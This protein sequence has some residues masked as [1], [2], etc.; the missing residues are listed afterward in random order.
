MLRGTPRYDNFS[1][2]RASGRRL[3]SRQGRHSAKG[4]GGCCD[5]HQYAGTGQ[6]GETHYF[7]LQ[8][9][10]LAYPCPHALTTC[11]PELSRSTVAVARNGFAVRE[12]TPYKYIAVQGGA[13]RD[14]KPCALFILDI[15]LSTWEYCTTFTKRASRDLSCMNWIDTIGGKG[16]LRKTIKSCKCPNEVGPNP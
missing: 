12:C 6:L 13:I 5:R 10:T 8:V 16:R 2:I 15:Q 7:Y 3:H 4:G 9:E 14:T 1:Y 11:V